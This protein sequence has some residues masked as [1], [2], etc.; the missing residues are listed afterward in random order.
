M[1]RLEDLMKGAIVRGVLP[2]LPTGSTPWK[3]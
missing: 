2:L 3:S 1:A